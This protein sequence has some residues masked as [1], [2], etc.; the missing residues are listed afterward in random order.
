M[1]STTRKSPNQPTTLHTPAPS[2]EPW[3]HYGE[4]VLVKARALAAENDKLLKTIAQL[5]ADLVAA[6]TRR[7]TELTRARY[8]ISQTI[9]SC[10]VPADKAKVAMASAANRWSASRRV[11]R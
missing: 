8:I 4:V 7:E 2:Q 6:E 1:K 10:K 9:I 11:V 5:K 3:T